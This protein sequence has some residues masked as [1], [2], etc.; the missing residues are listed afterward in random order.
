MSDFADSQHEITCNVLFK[1]YLSTLVS[2]LFAHFNLFSHA[3]Y[4][5]FIT[6]KIQYF[7]YKLT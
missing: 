7:L 2:A 4:T 1:L 5:H 6:I 3:I